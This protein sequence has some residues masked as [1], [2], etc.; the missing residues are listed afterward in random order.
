MRRVGKHDRPCATSK[1]AVEAA[2]GNLRDVVALRIYIVRGV[3][4][5]LGAV[6]SA[7]KEVFT[8]DPPASTWIG[9]SSLATPDFLVE[10]EATAVLE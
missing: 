5:E 8:V 6:G 7:L 9:V 3:E 10:I 2:G 4:Q 1:A